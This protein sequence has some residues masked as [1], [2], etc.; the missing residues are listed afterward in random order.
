MKLLRS[1]G[2][3]L[4]IALILGLLAVAVPAGAQ[5]LNTLT[6]ERVLVLSSA[7]STL[8]PNLPASLLGSVTSGALEIHEQTNYNPQASLLTSTFFV[9]PAGSTLPTSLSTVPATNYLATLSLSVDKTYVTSS[10]VQFAGTISQSSAPLFGSA[11][12]QGAPATLS[13]GYTKD[14]PPKIHDVIESIA[15]VAVAYTGAATGTLTITQPT[16]PGGPGGGTGVTIVI[17][18]PG[19]S[20]TSNTFQTTVNQ[21]ALDA[22]GSKSTNAGALTY[23]WS[24]PQG[25]PSAVIS[26]PGGDTTKPF[27]QLI[28]GQQTYTIN[29]TVTD[30]TGATAT[31]TITIQYL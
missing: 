20:N 24:I 26:F 17:V 4:S 14:T 21:V 10:A 19:G 15:G 9:M 11:S 22:S 27:V 3:A 29:L 13:F 12:Y 30:A 8:T 25:S 31:S 16:T 5:T 1:I 18:G 2:G 7:H 23:T 6:M 28:S